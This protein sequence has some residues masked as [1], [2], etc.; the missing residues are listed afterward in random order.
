MLYGRDLTTLLALVLGWAYCCR[1]AGR[2]DQRSLRRLVLGQVF[3]AT[4]ATALAGEH[5]AGLGFFLD[6]Q[7]TWPGSV[8]ALAPVAAAAGL[9]T[10]HR[11]RRAADGG[12][13]PVWPFRAGL[14]SATALTAFELFPHDR[15]RAVDVLMPVAVTGLAVGID[16][17]V[18]A[19]VRG[20]RRAALAAGLAVLALTGTATG[21]GLT[22]PHRSIPEPT[23]AAVRSGRVTSEGDTLYYEVRGKGTPLLLIAGGG[24]DGGYYSRLADVLAPSYEVITYDRRGNA[25]STRNHPRTFSLEQQARD[26]LAVLHAAGHESADVMGSSSGGMVALQLV[27]DAPR[28]VR[29]LVVHEVALATYSP[30]A[31]AF[32]RSTAQAT[33]RYGTAAAVAQFLFGVGI[34]ASAL[35]ATPEQAQERGYDPDFVLSVELPGL[36]TAAPDAGRIV[37][38]GVPVVCAVGELTRRQGRVQGSAMASLA[39]DL[40]APLV[41]FPGHHLSYQD[42][43]LGW[44][45]ALRAALERD[46]RP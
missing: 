42:D 25:R 1:Q 24:G 5:A 36:I 40:H 28:A 2:A 46:G 23:P 16:R 32:L 33:A 13:L 14:Y 8:L 18:P 7:K 15:L 3:T 17:L 11:A 22:V 45:A 39:A 31:D 12:D 10:R 37:A 6:D 41:V 44:A 19:R 30:R 35:G 29:R 43:P 9:S 20:G 26:A 27:A 38:S 21:A 34:P 4:A